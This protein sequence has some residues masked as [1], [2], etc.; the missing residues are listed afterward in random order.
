MRSKIDKMLGK[1]L[2]V[3]IH[4]A[5]E[6]RRLKEKIHQMVNKNETPSDFLE[7]IEELKNQRRENQKV[8]LS[9]EGRTDW[10]SHN[11]TMLHQKPYDVIRQQKR[12]AMKKEMQLSKKHE[13]EESERVA[14]EKSLHKKALRKELQNHITRTVMSYQNDNRLVR[15]WIVCAV[16]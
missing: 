12:A 15:T 6:A 7:L 1:D 13:L 9:S 11:A 10:V 3:E 14:H 8:I 2:F 4:P 16:I 5:K